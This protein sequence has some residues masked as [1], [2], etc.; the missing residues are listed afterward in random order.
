MKGF[1]PMK[2]G[3]KRGFDFPKSF[4]FSGSTGNVTLVSGYKRQ[5]FAKGGAVKREG[6]MTVTKLGDVGNAAVVRTKPVTNLDQQYGGRGPLR[7]GYK[8]GGWIAGATK[9][10]GALHRALGV[11]EGEKIPEKKM[12]KAAKSDSPLMRK[13][14]ALAKTLKSFNKADGGLIARSKM[15]ESDRRFARARMDATAKTMQ[16]VTE[17]DYKYGPAPKRSDRAEYM[18]RLKR[19]TGGAVNSRGRGNQYRSGGKAYC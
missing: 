17:R 16:P 4:G 6:R 5:K 14:V 19:A 9:N 7:P 12:A 18:T 2:C 8:T 11:P 1:T 15:T 10:K 13:R 3:Y